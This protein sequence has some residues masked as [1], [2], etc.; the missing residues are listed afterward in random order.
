[1][2]K[3]KIDNQFFE[4]VI[5]YHLLTNEEYLGTVID[6]IDTRYFSNK[7]IKVVVELIT[8]FFLKRG[9]APTLTELKSYL[10]TE[11]LKESFRNVV[12][13][14]DDVDKNYNSDELYENTEKFLKENAVYHT[15]L[16]VIDEYQNK[17]IDSASILD[18]FEKACSVTISGDLGHDFFRQL[19]R[20]IEDLEKEDKYIPSNWEWL[21]RK[22]NGGFLETGRSMYLFAG[23]TNVGKSIFL[24]NIACN[25][26]AQGKTVLL[27]SL[28]MSELMYAKRISS[29][30]SRVPINDLTENTGILKDNI[31]AY[32]STHPKSRLIIKEFP[33][34][35]ITANHLNGYIKKLVNKGIKPD[36][37]V[38][39]YINL[40]HCPL[41]NNSYERVKHAAEQV[42]ALSYTYECPF[43]TATQI[44][45][46]GLNEQNPG[47][48]NISES[49]GLAATA[50]CI[51]SIWQDEGDVELGIIRMG[52][53]KNRYGQ[54]FGTCTM[55][56]DYTTL[57]LSQ[58]Q[59][60]INTEE[61]TA[62]D[63]AFS[64][65]QEN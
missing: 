65:L 49:I 42:R 23:G 44:N 7:D 9:H 26:A 14:F 31:T 13:M 27:I 24:G 29:Q 5:A 39:D 25:V 45:R 11:D 33:P 22:L 38:L 34:N 60:I 32:K 8:D 37:V 19:D 35:A 30:L 47:V 40:L 12:K 41:G 62:I 21:D 53:V 63:E 51:M 36:M 20:H 2:D 50:D 10:S 43:I 57:T 18:K 56:I 52:M 17:K 16:E 61:A 1:M 4:I 59:A 28:E 6:T 55:A 46:S 48:E 3:I 64:M 15:M 58:T 54:N